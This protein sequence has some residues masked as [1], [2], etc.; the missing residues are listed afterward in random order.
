MARRRS[1]FRPTAA[2]RDDRRRPRRAPRRL[3]RATDPAPEQPRA[4][5]GRRPRA[6]QGVAARLLEAPA[7]AV[8]D[9]G[10]GV[11]ADGRRSRRLPA[12]PAR[13]GSVHVC[14][15][16]VRARTRH[17]RDGVGG[18]TGAGRHPLLQFLGD[19]IRPRPM[20]AA[21]LGTDG[22]AGVSRPCRQTHGGL[23]ARGALPRTGILVE[24]CGFR[25]GR[26]HRDLPSRRSDRAAIMA[27]AR[28]LCDGGGFRD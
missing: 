3:D 23:G 9:R 21:V 2:R 15:V 11:S 10:R 16:A 14:G 24:I 12:R 8:V 18:G 20:S 6:R 22:L 1:R 26:H 7:T 28:P 17:A 5:P 19:E 25:A 4:R 13:R 27:D